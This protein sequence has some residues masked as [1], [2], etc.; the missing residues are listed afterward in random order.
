MS[1]L[2]ADAPT[3]TTVVIPLTDE[4][5]AGLSAVMQHA[6]KDD[7]TPVIC[8][9]QVNAQTFVATDRYSVGEYTHDAAAAEPGESVT[10]PR[11]AAEWLTKQNQ[12]SL[13]AVARTTAPLFAAIVTAESIIIRWASDDNVSGAIVAVH[14]FLEV[15]G[16]Y[17]PVARLF[18]AK[19]AEPKIM[20]T[21]VVSL[22]AVQLEKFTRGC[23]KMMGTHSPMTITFQPSE[24]SNKPGP[25][26]ITFGAFRGLL[27]PN[28]LKR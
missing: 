24:N 8:T 1:T 6:S 17:P 14:T 16:N 19:D 21:P 13:G 7:I 25:V 2:I 4:T 27:Q 22:G 3:T 9:V 28:W 5:L 12:K 10:I 23:K 11:S 20:T 18:P 26:L 15:K